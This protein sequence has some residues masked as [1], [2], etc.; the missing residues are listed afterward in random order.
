M[1]PWQG[2]TGAGGSHRLPQGS[3]GRA[4]GHARH[5]RMA[6]PSPESASTD[7]Q[8]SPAMASDHVPRVRRGQAASPHFSDE[9]SKAQSSCPSTLY[10]YLIKGLG[11]ACLA[12]RGTEHMAP[13]PQELPLQGEAPG[14]HAQG[15]TLEGG[16]SEGGLGDSQGG[17]QVPRTDSIPSFTPCT[18][19]DP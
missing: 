10:V 8:A 4:W 19:T 18:G 11:T 17:A 6:H 7:P 15:G 14:L 9:K 13:T 2:S 12:W 16:P 3:A 5:P 1:C